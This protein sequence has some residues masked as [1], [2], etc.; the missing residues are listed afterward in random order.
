MEQEIIDTIITRPILRYPGSKWRLASW[1]HSFIPECHD[2]YNEPFVGTA[3]V[4]LRKPRSRM[5]NINDAS[6]DLI[7]FLITLRTH[8][9]ELIRAI[10]RTYWT[11]AELEIAMAVTDEPI[12]WARRFYVRCWANFH[13]F[14]SNPS[15]RRQMKISRQNGRD[16]MTPASKQFMRTDHLYHAAARL[17]GVCIE[18]MDAIKFIGM[19]DYD[20]AI[21]YIDPPYPFGTRVRANHYA[22]DEMSDSHHEALSD[23]LMGIDGMAIVSGYACDLYADLYEAKG[24]ARVDKQTRTNGRDRLESLWISP[25]TWQALESERLE[26]E[27]QALPLF[28][29]Q[30]FPF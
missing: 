22:I 10:E 1:I 11:P 21:F 15:F 25:S 27:R 12:E 14:D 26:R 19:Y 4:L 9:A 5:E 20:K 2:T 8:E 17:R 30:P 24:W 28:A 16:A 18:Q 6:G 29:D 13:P 23:V 7:N 3:S